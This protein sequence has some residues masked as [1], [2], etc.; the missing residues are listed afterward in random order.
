[1]I[2]VVKLK[3]AVTNYYRIEA[4]SEEEAMDIVWDCS[5][6]LK[7]FCEDW[8]TVSLDAEEESDD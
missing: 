6:T 7:P 1:M 2:Y 5:S 4:D 3:E 8:E